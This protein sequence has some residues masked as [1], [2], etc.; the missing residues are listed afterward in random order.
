M[1]KALEEK[2]GGELISVYIHQVALKVNDLEWSIRLD[3]VSVLA[4]LFCDMI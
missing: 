1:L 4:C 2:A 3:V